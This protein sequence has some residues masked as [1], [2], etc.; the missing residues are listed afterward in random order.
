M[1]AHNVYYDKSYNKDGR[2]HKVA[3]QAE[4]IWLKEEKPAL[5]ISM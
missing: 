3:A 4:V 5:L 1:I 2:N